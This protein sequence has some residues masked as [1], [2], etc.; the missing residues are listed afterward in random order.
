MARALRV[1]A[2]G[3]KPPP[4]RRPAKAA[5]KP[6]TV[7]EAAEKGTRKELLVAMRTRIARAVDDLNTPAR[8]LAALTKRLGEV[9]RDIEALEAQAVQEESNGDVPDAAFNPDSI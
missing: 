4:R 5:P 2:P 6:K 3:E 9:D 7:L 8:D 1:V